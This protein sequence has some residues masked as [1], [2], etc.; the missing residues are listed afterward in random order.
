MESNDLMDANV[1]RLKI[2]INFLKE[3]WEDPKSGIVAAG[4]FDPLYPPVLATSYQIQEGKWIHAER[5]ALQLFLKKHERPGPDTVV[6][7]TLSPCLKMLSDS[8]I[9]NSCTDLLC[10][11]KLHHV[12]AGAMDS[13]QNSFSYK[14]YKKYGL[15]LTLSIDKYCK[16]VCE[17]LLKI[18]QEYGSKVNI[19]LPTI[20]NKIG[21]R[22]FELNKNSESYKEVD[23]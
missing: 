17:G 9:G 7:V 5:H 8:R 6:I 22:I 16:R 23:M 13:A 12:Y 2:V 21:Y 1:D 15:D 18:F 20:K 10:K 11:H 19:D 3:N 4:I 14:E